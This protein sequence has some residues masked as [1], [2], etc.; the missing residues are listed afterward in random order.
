MLLSMALLS[1]TPIVKA[2]LAAAALVGQNSTEKA[3]FTLASPDCG[4]SIVEMSTVAIA[5][6]AAARE[7][8]HQQTPDGGAVALFGQ[9]RANR[10]PGAQRG[11]P[12]EFGYH[13]YV[14]FLSVLKLELAV[15]GR[16]SR[17]A[18]QREVVQGSGAQRGAQPM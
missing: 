16:V 5:A 3:L 4:V 9:K 8:A 12:L 10:A 1:E 18:C 14:D 15:A 17:S 7:E 2:S 13:H 6:A 11:A